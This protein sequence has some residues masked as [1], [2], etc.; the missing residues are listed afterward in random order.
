MT[1]NFD[2]LK[3]HMKGPCS[4]P[5]AAQEIA[6]LKLAAESNNNPSDAVTNMQSAFW[7]TTCRM[8]GYLAAHEKDLGYHFFDQHRPELWLFK[9]G[10]CGHGRSTV[11]K[12][13][14]HVQ[15]NCGGDNTQSQEDGGLEDGRTGDGEAAH[16]EQVGS[17]STTQ[18]QAGPR[19]LTPL[20]QP[21]NVRA[22]PSQPPLSPTPPPSEELQREF[23]LTDLMLQEVKQQLV[24][25]LKEDLGG[26]VESAIEKAFSPQQHEAQPT[27]AMKSTAHEV[28]T[29]EQGGISGG[30]RKQA[31]EAEARQLRIQ[32]HEQ[33]TRLVEIEEQLQGG[34]EED[35]EMEEDQDMLEQYGGEYQEDDSDASALTGAASNSLSSNLTSTHFQR[36]MSNVTDLENPMLCRLCSLQCTKHKDLKAHFEASHP[37]DKAYVC[38]ECEGC[39][40]M[41]HREL[42]RHLRE[43]CRTRGATTTAEEAR[44]RAEDE[45]QRLVEEAEIRRLE[46]E[47]EAMMAEQA[48]AEKKARKRKLRAEVSKIMTQ[49][50]RL[51]TRLVRAQEELKAEEAEESSSEDEDVDEMD[52]EE[53]GQQEDSDEEESEADDESLVGFDS[54][55]V[56]QNASADYEQAN[57]D[58]DESESS[59]DNDDLYKG[60]SSN[61][62][63]MASNTTDIQ[64]P[65]RCRICGLDFTRRADLITHFEANHAGNQPFRCAA[66]GADFGRFST[67]RRHQRQNCPANRAP[68]AAGTQ[69]EESSKDAQASEDARSSEDDPSSEVEV[70]DVNTDEDHDESEDMGEEDSSSGSEAAL[71]SNSTSDSGSAPEAVHPPSHSPSGSSSASEAVRPPS[72]STDT[73]TRHWRHTCR[74]CGEDLQTQ[75]SL[76]RHFRAEHG[77]DRVHRCQHCGSAMTHASSLVRHQR[78]CQGRTEASV[79]DEQEEHDASGDGDEEDQE[80]E[81]QE[82]EVYEG[83]EAAQEV[84]AEAEASAGEEEAS[85]QEDEVEEQVEEAPEFDDPSY[86]AELLELMT[87]PHAPCCPNI[88][89]PRS[90]LEPLSLFPFHRIKSKKLYNLS[91]GNATNHEH[92]KRCRICQQQFSSHPR[93]IEHHRAAHPE[94]KVYQC[95]GCSMSSDDYY[96]LQRHM[97]KSCKGGQNQGEENQD[98]DVEMEDA[99]GDGQVNNGQEEENQ[100]PGQVQVQSGGAGGEEEEGGEGASALEHPEHFDDV[101][102]VEASEREVLEMMATDHSAGQPKALEEPDWEQFG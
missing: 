26:V 85:Q 20:A 23:L 31:L 3:R 93:L 86:A 82:D 74:I 18:N 8:C 11:K 5:N 94:G 72:N 60:F 99:P 46:E 30:G 4:R 12:F 44:W 1:N 9:C 89:L 91:N 7:R 14:E 73:S 97:R 83:E 40:T 87:D 63:T 6:Q 62:C 102:V 69:G 70:E 48:R 17:A 84:E 37:H 88:G 92:P 28:A 100:D 96:T 19:S 65:N 38:P 15:Y 95:G 81:D 22:L 45:A 55:Q 25:S 61:C 77:S 33:A 2:H 36:T 52:W 59:S 78:T 90:P 56:E 54:Q 64:H 57:S 35:Q 68:P 98:G 58:D 13:L 79:E 51:A 34:V 76:Q 42:L 75:R 66:C 41:H 16:T 53:E 67:L 10:G 24:H 27:A 39:S 49:M 29:A 101:E 21:T 43:G 80:E 71:P 32:L 50:N 47:E